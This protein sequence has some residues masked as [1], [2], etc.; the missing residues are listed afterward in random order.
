M[1]ERAY[2]RT[3]RR[4]RRCHNDNCAGTGIILTGQQYVRAVAL[5]GHDNNPT[6]HPIHADVCQSCYTRWDKPMPPRYQR[7]TR[8]GTAPL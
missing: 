7:P 8:K 4:F 3:S 5:P 2:T 6:N 1:S